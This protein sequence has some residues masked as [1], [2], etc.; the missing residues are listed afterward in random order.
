MKKNW[1][2]IALALSSV[3]CGSGQNKNY[4]ELV[5]HGDSIAK[6]IQSSLAGT[7]GELHADRVDSNGI[8]HPGC[9]V[10]LGSALGDKRFEFSLPDRTIDL[11]YAGHITYWVNAIKLTGIEMSS[12]TKD[13][14]LTA[15]F[16]SDGVTLKGAHSTLGESVIPGIK[17]DRMRLVV[18]LKPVVTTDGKIT[19]DDPRVE[20]T[21]DVDNTFIPR[22]TIMGQT[23]DVVDALTHYRSD[24]C[25]S[26]R[27]EV[28]K[29]LD[30]PTRKAALA[31]K[32][33][34]G[35]AGPSSPVLGLRF[36]GT[37]LIVRLRR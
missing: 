32:I 24:L 13:F 17:L 34:D 29:A 16:S 37:D 31:Q 7:I 26:V 36:Q 8:H 33:Q 23:V 28:Q 12:S 2:L 4:S 1:I 14:V 22:F 18:H 10:Q 5:L 20:F 9:F 25:N 21:A 27:R 15:S 30:D 11:G 6:Q 3:A 19:Y 35:I